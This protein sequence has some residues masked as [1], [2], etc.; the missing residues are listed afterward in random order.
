MLATIH[1]LR[2]FKVFSEDEEIGE[3]EDYYFDRKYW[4]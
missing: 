2:G 3:V 1:E 4:D